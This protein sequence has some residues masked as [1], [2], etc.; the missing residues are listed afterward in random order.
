MLDKNVGDALLRLDLS[1]STEPP[2]A[3]IERI[4]D[5]DRRRV[6]R[7]TW[8]AVALWILAAL[9]GVFISVMGGLTFPM[10][11]KMV[12]EENEKATSAK[13]TSEKA[14]NETVAAGTAD[15]AKNV[16]SHTGTVEEPDT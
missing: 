11:A 13:A 14:A 16:K 8:I 15:D 7:W 12:M 2:T 9:G 3:Q 10:I 6:R 4:I 1:P 5:I